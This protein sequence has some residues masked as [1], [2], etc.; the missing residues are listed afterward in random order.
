MNLLPLKFKG[1]TNAEPLLAFRPR[2]LACAVV[3]ASLL[4]LI[5]SVQ[6]VGGS[7]T[8]P[9]SMTRPRAATLAGALLPPAN[10]SANIVPS[11][12]FLLDCAGAAYDDAPTCVNAVVAADSL[13]IP[14]TPS[15]LA[16]EG[17][18]QLL[19]SVKQI[20]ASQGA[21]VHP[22][23]ILLTMV[24]SRMRLTSDVIEMLRN[25]YGEQVLTTEIKI[26][27]KLAEVSSFGQSIFEYDS[28]CPGARLYLQAMQELE[29]RCRVPAVAAR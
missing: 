19:S 4:L 7:S 25:H 21:S 16:V 26:N 24:D 22:V 11:P 5:L 13:L 18:V 8:P 17:L 23:G 14:V 1:D 2:P 27:V 12:D 15:Y 28:R 20:A 6:P 3:L 10:P 29:A 9:T